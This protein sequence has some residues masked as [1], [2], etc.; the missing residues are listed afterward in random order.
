MLTVANIPERREKSKQKLLNC[1]LENKAF[2][3][4]LDARRYIG[5]LQDFLSQVGSKHKKGFIHVSEIF[6]INFTKYSN[7]CIEKMS[8]L[9]Y[10]EIKM[11]LV[12]AFFMALLPRNQVR[13]N[14]IIHDK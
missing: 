4:Y 11:V 3:L 12:I 10:I 13:H 2:E 7:F 9:K 14:E 6:F 1:L 5:R 8:L